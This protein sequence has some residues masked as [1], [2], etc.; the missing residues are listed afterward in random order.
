MPR[1]LCLFVCLLTLWTTIGIGPRLAAAERVHVLIDQ[2]QAVALTRRTGR[3]L[4]AIGGTV[5]CVYCVRMAKQLET[6]ESVAPAA[7]KF[8]ILK[9]DTGSRLWREWRDKYDMDGDGVPQVVILRADGK[10][11]YGKTG[12]P[13][14]LKA[15]LEQS[16]AQKHLKKKDY[17]KATELGLECAQ[18]DCHA[19]VVLE[20]RKLLDNLDDRAVV[21]LK[22][23]E[24][25]LASRDKTLDGALALLDLEAAFGEHPSAKGRIQDA[26]ARQSEGEEKSNLFTQARQVR[27]AQRL[28]TAKQRPEA[29]SVWKQ[30]L[31]NFPDTPAA[32]LATR[33]L[34]DLEK[35]EGKGK[36]PAGKPAAEAAKGPPGN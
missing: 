35:R 30:I 34:T 6:D 32:A 22:E 13:A 16:L 10:Q 4:L 18:D 23:A 31:E 33:R 9:I 26:L 19:A 14:D 29:I 8:V 21:G 7:A 11:I 1:A 36:S 5:N 2:E 3:P 27:E 12:A 28:E 17:A 24:R 20:A 15:F 25:K